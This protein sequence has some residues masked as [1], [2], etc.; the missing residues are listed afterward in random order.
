MSAPDFVP[1][2][3]GDGLYR[4]GWDIFSTYKLSSVSPVKTDTDGRK[5]K[6]F[7][8]VTE[9]GKIVYTVTVSWTEDSNGNKSDPH[10][11]RSYP[12]PSGNN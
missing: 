8:Y 6:V 7:T 9:E 2:P 5:C 4:L 3:L 12:S 10:W 11:T 1:E